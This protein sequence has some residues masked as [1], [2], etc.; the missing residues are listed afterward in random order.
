M[1]DEMYL[2]FTDPAVGPALYPVVAYTDT[3]GRPLTAP[4]YDIE[5]VEADGTV[6][7]GQ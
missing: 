1:E 6:Y 4:W 3:A 5:F 7:L 2:T